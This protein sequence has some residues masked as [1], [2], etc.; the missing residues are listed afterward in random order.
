MLFIDTCV[1]DYGFFLC[2][3]H[4]YFTIF[5]HEYVNLQNMF[6]FLSYIYIY[7]NEIIVF[8]EWQGPAWVVGYV[9]IM[10]RTRWMGMLQFGI[11]ALISITKPGWAKQTD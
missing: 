6:V 5:P 8:M 3:L 2:M 10:P 7:L 1:Y 9:T 4:A 11:K